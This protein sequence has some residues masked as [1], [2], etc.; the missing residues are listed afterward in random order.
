[1]TKPMKPREAEEK[2]KKKPG[3]QHHPNPPKKTS[4]DNPEGNPR[5]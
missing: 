4:T 1:M 3:G 5:D 2:A